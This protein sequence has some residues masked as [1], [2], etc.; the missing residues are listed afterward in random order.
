MVMHPTSDRRGLDEDEP[1]ERAGTMRTTELRGTEKEPVPD[2]RGVTF[3]L[4]ASMKTDED[5]ASL[6]FDNGH[7]TSNSAT[8]EAPERLQTDALKH[9]EVTEMDANRLKASSHAIQI[10]ARGL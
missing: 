10:Q 1:D 2:D 6:G 7:Q 4:D 8:S 9:P 3:Q 5:T